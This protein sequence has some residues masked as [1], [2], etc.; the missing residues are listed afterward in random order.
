[1]LELI[2]HRIKDNVLRAV[3]NDLSD[4]L[5]A[6]HAA[7]PNRDARSELGVI[8]APGEPFTDTLFGARAIA[9]L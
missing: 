6:F 9:K 8:V 2:E 3:T 7:T 4:P 5:G 1:M